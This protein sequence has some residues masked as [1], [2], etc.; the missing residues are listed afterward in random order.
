MGTLTLIR[1]SEK[2]AEDGERISFNPWHL[3]PGIEPSNDPVLA[4]R[5]GAYEFSHGMRQ[6]CPF[7]GSQTDAR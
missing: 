4:A 6:K 1:V 2:Q 5:K 7:A 3:P